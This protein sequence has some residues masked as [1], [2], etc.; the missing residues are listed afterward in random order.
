MIL[1]KSV[2]KN[3]FGRKNL[4]E[5]LFRTVADAKD[6]KAGSIF[7]SGKRG[8]GKTKLLANLYN[9]IFK[10]QDSV[11]FLYTVK[12][13]FVSAE[14]FANDYL[15]SFIQ[16]GLAFQ[17]KD[18]AVLSG[19][20]SLEELRDGAKEFGAQ[21]AVDII[22]DYMKVRAEGGEAK[23][24][25][26]AV[27]APYRSYQITG[28]PVVVMIDDLHKI[29]RFCELKGNDITLGF[30]MPFESSIRSLHVPHIFSGVSH[31]IEKIYFEE[32]LMADQ[33]EMIDLPCLD[34][35][36][37]LKLFRATCEMYGLKVEIEP[38][39]F[40]G[41]FGGNPFYIKNFLQA[42]RH[43]GGVLSKDVFRQTYYNEITRGKT[44]KYWTFLLKGY[45]RRLDLRKPSLKFLYGL[46]GDN[47]DDSLQLEQNIF[48][49]ISEILHDS[50][51]V[52]TGFSETMPADEILK[53]IIKVLY[54]R[55]V[56]DESPDMVRKSILGNEVERI[57]EI[58]PASFIITIPATPKAGLVAIK[59]FEQIA[60]NYNIPLKAM[61]KLQLA[62]ADLFS[63]VLA[64]DTSAEN[65]KLQVKCIDNSFLVEISISQKDLVLTEQDSTRIRAYLDDLKIENIEDGTMITLVKKIR[66]DIIPPSG[67]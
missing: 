12:R 20:Y 58:D 62:M 63:N 14:D 56:Q 55:E 36:N 60:R 23:I 5:V 31:E 25:L 65:F 34:K 6:G 8:V 22:D 59:L 53:D 49:R 33:I 11:P 43:A 27:S 2:S 32:T 48:E 38:A 40:V 50:G 17:G 15:G 39:D 18:P 1:D 30:C 41:T 13:S 57:K 16:Q 9:L 67:D 44:Y 19:I 61:G 64:E 45:V 42:V 21:W 35:E 3:F 24:V 28:V 66:E 47:R 46:C 52:E 7:L 26:N 29:R 54:R 51:S 10:R 37:S 4:L